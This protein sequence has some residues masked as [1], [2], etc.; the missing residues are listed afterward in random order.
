MWALRIGRIERKDR[1][2]QVL[3]VCRY[4][5]AAVFAIE[6]L[7]AALIARSWNPESDESYMITAVAFYVLTPLVFVVLNYP[8]V[9]V[10]AT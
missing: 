1:F 10:Y 3:T 2:L 6:M 5:W 4:A 9:R 8:G 7:E